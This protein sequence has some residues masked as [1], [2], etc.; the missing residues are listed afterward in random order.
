MEQNHFKFQ[1]KKL[2]KVF[3]LEQENRNLQRRIHSPKVDL[4]E[5]N[6][7]YFVRIEV[8]GV[9]QEN[10]KFQLNDDQILL[11]SGIKKSDIQEEGEKVVYRECKYN[12]FMRRVKLPGKVKCMNENYT[13]TNGVLLLEFAKQIEPLPF[14]DYNPTASWA[15]D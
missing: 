10:L 15:D 2:S 11:V 8:P 1:N 13:L 7:H 3:L 4:V 5:R 6:D 12:E 14:E 9:S